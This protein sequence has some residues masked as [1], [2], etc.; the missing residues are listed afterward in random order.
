MKLN[1]LK[2]IIRGWL[3]PEPNSLHNI[4][5]YSAPIAIGLAVTLISISVFAASSNFIFGSTAVRPLSP[6]IGVNDTAAQNNTQAATPQNTTL[7]QEQALA[8]AMPIIQQYAA[9]N[10]RTI[11]YVNVTLCKMTNSTRGG[12]TLEQVLQGN[13]SVADAQKQFI[14]YPVWEIN[15]RFDLSIYDNIPRPSDWQPW[16]DNG[17]VVSYSVL[18]WA[19]LGQICSSSPGVIAIM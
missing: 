12:P 1:Y 7:T 14:Y 4:R 6:V 5:R 2:Q 8:M 19:D 13:I 3:P 9:E 10:N 16:Y 17:R 15:A 11:L 18:V